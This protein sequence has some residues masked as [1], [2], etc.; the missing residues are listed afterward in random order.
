MAGRRFSRQYGNIGWSVDEGD[1]GGR[2]DVAA[3][4]CCSYRLC[5]RYQMLV[6]LTRVGPVDNAATADDSRSA[7][8]CGPKPGATT[9][10]D[11]DENAVMGAG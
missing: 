1:E 7:A 9:F 11:S 10:R 3:V 4:L 5:C 6:R 2:D 8:S